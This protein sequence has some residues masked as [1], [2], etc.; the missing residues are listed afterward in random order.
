[1]M[2]MIMMTRNDCRE[3]L[4]RRGQRTKNNTLTGSSSPPSKNKFGAHEYNLE[5]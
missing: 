3:T 5:T 2:I 4:V 1:M